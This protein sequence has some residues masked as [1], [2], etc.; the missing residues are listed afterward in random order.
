MPRKPT[1]RPAGRPQGSGKLTSNR[2]TMTLAPGQREALEQLA[3]VKGVKMNV[4]L[5]EAIAMYI[6]T[7]ESEGDAR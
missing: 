6:N 3:A 1:G 4:V 5:R 2:V 7:Q